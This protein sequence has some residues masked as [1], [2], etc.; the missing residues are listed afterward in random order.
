MSLVRTSH[1]RPASRVKEDDKNKNKRT[2]KRTN[3]V[4]ILAQ[5]PWALSQGGVY[6][7]RIEPKWLRKIFVCAPTCL[8]KRVRRLVRLM[9]G[10]GSFAPRALEIRTAIMASAENATDAISRRVT[11]SRRDQRSEN[12][13]QVD[14]GVGQGGG[15]GERVGTIPTGGEEV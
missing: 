1:A 12:A 7:I 6:R 3:T 14:E 2:N 15:T 8:S 9:I 13:S 10:C 4:A 5:A 11:P